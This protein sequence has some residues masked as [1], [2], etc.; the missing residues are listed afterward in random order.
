MKRLRSLP[1]RQS[2]RWQ[3]PMEDPVAAARAKGLAIFHVSFAP[4][5][6]LDQRG[7]NVAAVRQRLSAIGEI[8]SAAP[9]VREKGSIVF[10]FVTGLREVPADFT[11]WS[12]DGITFKPAPSVASGISVVPPASTLGG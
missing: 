8:L 5:P 2:L 6:A 7:V 4:S 11:V 9:V 1:R 3:V 12:A 10:E